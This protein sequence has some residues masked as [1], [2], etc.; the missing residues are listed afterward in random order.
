MIAS[1]SVRRD[2]GMGGHFPPWRTHE[3]AYPC[4]YFPD[5]LGVPSPRPDSPAFRVEIYKK[6]IYNLYIG[7]ICKTFNS[8]EEGDARAGHR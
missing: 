5:F 1:G 3:H 2:I 6:P 4:P 7:Y 8:R